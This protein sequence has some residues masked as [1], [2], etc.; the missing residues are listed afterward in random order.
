[1]VVN[2]TNFTG[3]GA[4]RDLSVTIAPMRIVAASFG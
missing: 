4:I 1:M 3:A 2:W